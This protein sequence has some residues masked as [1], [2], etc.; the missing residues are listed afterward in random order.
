M[1]K[2]FIVEEIE[3]DNDGIG[4]DGCLFIFLFPIIVSFILGIFSITNTKSEVKQIKQVPFDKEISLIKNTEQ[5]NDSIKVIQKAYERNLKKL[6]KQLEKEEKKLLKEQKKLE[7]QK[8]REEKRNKNDSTKVIQKVDKRNLKKLQKQLEKEEK[9]LL[10]EQKKLE[11]QKLR[12]E[13]NS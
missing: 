12:E 6:K 4:C 3:E 7:K 1:G 13:K 8:L 9:K 11:K 10:K 5:K 2:R